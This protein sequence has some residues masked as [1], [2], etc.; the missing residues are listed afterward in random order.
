MNYDISIKVKSNE[1][2][3]F[4]AIASEL[5]KWWGKV[6]NQV[7]NAGDEFSILFGKTKWRFLVTEFSRTTKISWNCIKAKHF[8]GGF[9]NIEEEWLNTELFWNFKKNNGYVEVL[10]EH[11]WLTSSLNCYDNCESDWNFFISTSSK[12]YLETGQEN[13]RFK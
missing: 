10:L 11:N 8:V 2:N 13:P 5:D 4:N 1:V 9:T 3:A 7:T 12:N 6:D